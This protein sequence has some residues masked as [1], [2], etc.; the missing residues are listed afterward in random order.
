MLAI[1]LLLLLLKLMLLLLLNP[2]D[3]RWSDGPS[4]GRSYH[5]IKSLD[6]AAAHSVTCDTALAKTNP[7]RLQS[8][9]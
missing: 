1:C 6:S 3:A 8:C 9:F 5:M 2:I 4:V 7:S